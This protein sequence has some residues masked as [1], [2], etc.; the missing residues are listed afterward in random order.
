MNKNNNQLS[1]SDDISLKDLVFNIKQWFAYLKS[2]WLIIIFV[3]I[4][5]GGGGIVYA[6]VQKNQYTATL[7]FVLEED[8]PSIG[9]MSG[10]LGL[11][12]SLGFDL[13]SGS[14]GVFSGANL[15]ELMKSR[16]L[17]VKTLLQPIQVSKKTKLSLADWLI[18][19][20]GMR[21]GLSTNLDS[22][23]VHFEIF[24]DPQKFTVA[25]DSLM[26]I[27]WRKIV[28]TN[29]MLSVFQKDKKVGIITIETKSENELFSKIFTEA[30]ARVVSD[31]YIETKSKKAKQNVEILQKQTDSVRNALNISITGVA[32]STDNTYNLNPALN[33]KRTPVVQ[34]QIDVQTNTAMLA[35]LIPSLEIAKVSLRNET[36]LIQI[37][38]SPVFPLPK[39]KLGKSKGFIFGIFISVFVAVF[40]IVLYKIQK[41]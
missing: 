13:G 27:L 1:E 16:S 4:L 8:K 7:T 41:N 20:T 15:M 10:A 2:K 35:Q 21:S 17:V 22:S 24:A 26:S 31:F 12:S 5:G 39:E 6:I 18:D 3:S 36:P 19:F 29:G 40:S 37:I 25:Q 14:N 33:S 32:V 11:A 23:K 9:G 38:D 28:S 34:K 30:L